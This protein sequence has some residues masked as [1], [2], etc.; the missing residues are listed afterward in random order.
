MT[1]KLVYPAAFTFVSLGILLGL[2]FWQ[3]QRRSEKAELIQTIQTRIGESPAPLAVLGRL[4]TLG[5]PTFAYRPVRATGRFDHGQ[6]AHVFFALAKPKNGIGGPGYLIV[7]PFHLTNGGTILVNRGFVPQ[8]R[9][10]A[11][12]REGGQVAGESEITGLIRL[13]ERRGMFANPDDPARN[14]FYVRDPLTIAASRGLGPVAPV[15]IDLKTPVPAGG[16]PLPDVTLVDIPN[17]HLQYAL[18]WWSLAAVLGI[19]FLLWSRQAG[20]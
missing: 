19:I 7:T 6:E 9:K 4:E 11:A 12:S 16:L 3:W 20:R 17:N 5:Q 13:P 15:I 2:G 14:I 1:R 10:A 8:D 18:T